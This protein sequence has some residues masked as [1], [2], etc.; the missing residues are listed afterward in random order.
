MRDKLV[1]TLKT[2]PYPLRVVALVLIFNGMF[3]LIK[4]ATILIGNDIDLDW[5]VVNMAI[6]F[7]LFSKRR[8]WLISACISIVASAILHIKSVATA[9]SSYQVFGAGGVLYFLLALILDLGMLYILL[10]HQTLK[11]S[12]NMKGSS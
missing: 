3:A 5:R 6:G 10:R 2:V 12:S 8:F 1:D 4:V 9:I 11:N 7:G